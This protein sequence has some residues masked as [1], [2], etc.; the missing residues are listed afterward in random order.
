MRCLGFIPAR[1]GSKGVPGKNLRAVGGRPLIAWTI[2]AALAAAAL[3]RV[4]VSTDSEEIAA[5]ARS[6]G[7]EVPFL[8]PAAL[9]D[10]QAT[11][12]SA[13]LHGLDWLAGAGDRPDAIVLLQPTSPYRRPGRIDQA[14]AR[15]RAEQADSLVGVS[16]LHVFLWRDG[17]MP[18]ATYDPRR[19]PRRQD[20]PP[21]QRQ[22]QENGSLYITRTPV[23]LETGSRLAGRI[24]LFEMAEAERHEL[25]SGSDLAYLDF[26]LRNPALADPECPAVSPA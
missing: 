7:A 13:M 19:R 21:D 6:H 1:G 26:I 15:F 2:E 14:V 10:D 24:I 16:P 3:D 12:E 25:D 17:P 20:I 5:V 8:R 11:T 22:Y 9:A 4:I 23:L 18:Q